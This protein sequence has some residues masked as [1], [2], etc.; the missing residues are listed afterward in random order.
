MEWCVPASVCVSLCV[1]LLHNLIPQ[2]LALV[3]M[4]SAVCCS[5]YGLL[6]IR[7]HSNIIHSLPEVNLLPLYIHVLL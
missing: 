4:Q 7:G 2:C 3:S 6:V 1:I 5:N